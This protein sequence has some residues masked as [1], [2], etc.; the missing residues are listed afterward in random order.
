MKPACCL[1]LG[2]RGWGRPV[3]QAP[4][5]PLHPRVPC[6]LWVS[7]CCTRRFL[8][9]RG[10]WLPCRCD[11]HPSPPHLA[12]AGVSCPASAAQSSS[13]PLKSTSLSP[14]HRHT[15]CPHGGSV[16]SLEII[17]GS[18]SAWLLT[19]FEEPHSFSPAWAGW[20]GKRSPCPLEAGS[21]CRQWSK[22]R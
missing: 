18:L 1:L 10:L 7:T 21:Q 8:G 20:V 14:S 17:T 3:S 4:V 19:E 5:S 13:C 6:G 22:G 9:A 12:Q 2:Q 11:Q 16:P 15:R